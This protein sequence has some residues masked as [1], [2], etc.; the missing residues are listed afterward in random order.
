MAVVHIPGRRPFGQNLVTIYIDGEQRMN[1][2]LHF[3]SLSEVIESET[4]P[5]G[6]A[7]YQS[8]VLFHPFP[9]WTWTNEAF[10]LLL[11]W[12]C[13][14]PD[15]YHHLPQPAHDLTLQPIIAWVH[16]PH[17]R[18]VSHPIPVF[19]CL[20]RWRPLELRRGHRGARHP[21]R[22]AGLGVGDTHVSRRAPGHRL[23]LPQASAAGTG[24]S[25]ACCRLVGLFCSLNAFPSVLILRRE[26][27][28]FHIQPIT[29][30]FF[31]QCRGQSCVFIQ[32]RW[33]AIWPQQQT[34]ALLHSRGVI[35]RKTH[36]TF[37]MHDP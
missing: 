13:R 2:Q 32:S 12:L 37:G 5:C 19:P 25:S 27:F 20:L 4:E 14:P 28:Y 31:S 33:R 6:F 35:L 29:F 36:F 34:S 17:S 18:P 10:Y 3:P 26:L 1:A 23:H 7:P 22:V 9:A 8:N 30:D 21:G 16:L 11:H 24:Q 15:H